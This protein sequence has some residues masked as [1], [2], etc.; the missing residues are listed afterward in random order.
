MTFASQVLQFTHTLKP[1][2]ALPTRFELLF[3]YESPETRRVM[4]AFYHQ[5]YNDTAPRIFIFGINPGRFGA[6]VTGIPFTDPLRLENNCGIRNNFPKKQELSALFVYQF[7]DTYGGPAAFYR[8]FYITSL[9]PLGFLKDGL[10]C[11]YYDD[12]KLQTAVTPFIATSIAT[13][14]AFG[15]SRK[16]ALCMGQGQNAKYFQKIN[17]QHGFFE[18]IIALPHPRWVMQYRRKQV[19]T[20]VDMYLH[21]FQQAI[22]LAS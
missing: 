5:Y 14:L 18:E 3:P 19:A 22:T 2:L 9:S 17:E 16:V 6:G 10:N 7:I 4:T 21:A 12:K 8:H 13:Q 20:F 1:D 15:T 11:N